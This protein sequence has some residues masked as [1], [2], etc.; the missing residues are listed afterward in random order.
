MPSS[1]PLVYLLVAIQVANLPFMVRTLLTL[2]SR[3]ILSLAGCRTATDPRT[4]IVRLVDLPATSKKRL[5]ASTFSFCYT[6]LFDLACELCQISLL[7][8]QIPL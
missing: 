5:H 1:L 6:Y 8:A 7:Y 3:G 4:N 2:Q